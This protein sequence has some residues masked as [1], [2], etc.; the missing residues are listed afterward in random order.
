[1]VWAGVDGA[2]VVQA[3]AGVT[4]LRRRDWVTRGMARMVSVGG[5]R[6]ESWGV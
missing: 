3:P 5:G 4:A 1:V 2:L 6:G